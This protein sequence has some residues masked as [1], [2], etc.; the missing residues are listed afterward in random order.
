M[1]AKNLKLIQQGLNDEHASLALQ[2]TDSL[3]NFIIIGAAK[4]ATTTLTT[5]LPKHPDIFISKPKE[6]KFFGRYYSKGWDWYANRFS[7]GQGL[8]LRGEG[9]TMYASQMKAFKDTP[10]LM[11]RHL[12]KLKLIYIVRHPLDRIV[13]HWRHYRGRHPECPDF[14][15]FMDNKKLRCLIVGC[16]MYYQQLSRFRQFYPDEQIHCMTFED[17]LSNPKKS[18]RSTLRFLGVKPKIKKLLDSNGCLPRVN[19]AGGKGRTF[20]E[21]PSWNPI[22]KWRVSRIVRH[23]SEQMLNYLGK[24]KTYWNF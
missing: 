13:S 20:V 24:P 11:H 6:P 21:K 14:S 12:P 19:E 16:S 2:H 1:S 22:L 7:D 9:S 4:S 17:L 5:I 10:E 18:L 8:A 3:P 15:D 23:D